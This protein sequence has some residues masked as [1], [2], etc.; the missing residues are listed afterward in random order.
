MCG[1]TGTDLF[2]SARS[3]KVTLTTIPELLASSRLPA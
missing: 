2:S 1:K 3:S